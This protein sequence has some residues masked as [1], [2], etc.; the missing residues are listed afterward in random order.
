MLD[1]IFSHNWSLVKKDCYWR[2]VYNMTILCLFS[3]YSQQ[4]SSMFNNEFI[5]IEQNGYQDQQSNY[6]Y[7]IIYKERDKN[8][9]KY[10][11]IWS[12]WMR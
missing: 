8:C 9:L 6:T 1:M 12:S 11:H 5:F 4:E 2:Y 3:Q 10:M 7:S